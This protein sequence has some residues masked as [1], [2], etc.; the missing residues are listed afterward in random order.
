MQLPD[1]AERTKMQLT[2]NRS[3]L[4]VKTGA[5][6]LLLCLGFVWLVGCT[7]VIPKTKKGMDP[8]AQQ[9]FSCGEEIPKSSV[10]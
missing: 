6:W 2:W 8:F 10:H 3:P 5:K 1:G 4:R 7:S 9:K